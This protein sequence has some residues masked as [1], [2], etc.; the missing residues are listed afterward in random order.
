MKGVP[1]P[2]WYKLARQIWNALLSGL[3]FLVVVWLLMTAPTWGAWI[4]EEVI[5]DCKTN[6]ADQRAR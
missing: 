3:C 2:P 4:D 5:C 1:V 6:L